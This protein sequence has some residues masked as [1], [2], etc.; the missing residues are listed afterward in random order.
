MKDGIKVGTLHTDIE[1]EGV[2][3]EAESSNGSEGP[4]SSWSVDSLMK[5]LRFDQKGLEISEQ[6]A[7]CNLLYKH[8][9]VFSAGDTDLERTPFARHNIDSRDAKTVKLHLRRV[10]LQL[11]EE[12]TKNIK[13]MMASGIIQ[14]LPTL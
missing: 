9:P 2:L 4:K 10:P 8:L 11:K 6:R 13:Q 7:I 3:G 14:H 12:C 1:M 5:Q